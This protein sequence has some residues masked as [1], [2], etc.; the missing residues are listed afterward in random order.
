MVL[1][2]EVGIY[3]PPYGRRS[4]LLSFKED[5][6]KRTQPEDVLRLN[7]KHCFLPI[8]VWSS[9]FRPFPKSSIYRGGAVLFFLRS[10]FSAFLEIMNIPAVLGLGCILLSLNQSKAVIGEDKKSCKWRRKK[11]KWRTS[12]F[13]CARISSNWV[14][15]DAEVP[16]CTLK[17]PFFLQWLQRSPQEAC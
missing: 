14:T 5:P 2:A 6:L 15:K 12:W 4:L 3:P 10:S 11:G 13:V 1:L 16:D 8:I 17:E 7:F 9:F